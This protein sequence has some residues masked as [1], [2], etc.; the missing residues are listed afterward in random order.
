[1]D[2]C[3]LEIKIIVYS[4]TFNTTQE[5]KLLHQLEMNVAFSHPTTKHMTEHDSAREVLLVYNIHDV[6][7]F[8]N[9]VQSESKGL[10]FAY[11][12]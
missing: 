7:R 11:V 4:L 10:Q 5:S 9:F 12:Y 1:M 3:P 6:L 2:H 8:L